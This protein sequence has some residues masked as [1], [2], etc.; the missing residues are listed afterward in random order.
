MPLYPLIAFKKAEATCKSLEETAKD[1]PAFFEAL[2][3]K[4]AARKALLEA[5]EQRKAAIRALKE[6][7]K[8]KKKLAIDANKAQGAL[9]KALREE[10]AASTSATKAKGGQAADKGK[11]IVQ[12]E[13][14]ASEMVA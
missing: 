2:K 10:Q 12:T 4:E 13:Q 6:A 5:D 7:K 8:N 14:V 11:G 3:K 1:T 9:Q